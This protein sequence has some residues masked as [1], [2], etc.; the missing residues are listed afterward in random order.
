[1]SL[2]EVN[3]LDS[4]VRHGEMMV[5]NELKAYHEVYPAGLHTSG[6]HRGLRSC[7]M[8]ASAGCKSLCTQTFG[9]S[10]CYRFRLWLLLNFTEL[11]KAEN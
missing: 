1:M 2:A 5:T 7:R 6:H 10:W 11:S 3:D 9:Q 4:I 8:A